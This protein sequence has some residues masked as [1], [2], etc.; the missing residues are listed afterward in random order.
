[1]AKVEHLITSQDF[2]AFVDQ[3]SADARSGEVAAR[4]VLDHRAAA[5]VAHLNDMN[6]GLR[7][8][9]SRIYADP[10]LSRVV[11]TLVARAARR[12][13]TRAA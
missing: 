4:L 9:K 10:A 3:P 12:K 6:A 13:K 1:M 5:L 8:G 11:A 7:A 2:E